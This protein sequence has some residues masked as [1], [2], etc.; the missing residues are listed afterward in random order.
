MKIYTYIHICKTR[1]VFQGN[2]LHMTKSLCL[3]NP[4]IVRWFLLTSEPGP[5]GVPACVSIRVGIRASPLKVKQCALLHWKFWW[6]KVILHGWI[7]LDDITTATTW[8]EIMLKINR[9]GW[10]GMGWDGMGCMDA[11]MLSLSVSYSS[12]FL[13]KLMMSG[14]QSLRSFQ[15]R[16]GHC[17]WRC[18][19]RAKQLWA[20]LEPEC[21][22]QQIKNHIWHMY[23]PSLAQ[24][25]K[26]NNT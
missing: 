24:I 11:C 22:W 4:Q 23:W 12:R 13:L 25:E 2:L 21:E 10:D 17:N 7:D 15:A 18:D 26:Q 9:I 14:E 19:V 1:L 3:I 20:F 8:K 6:N 5:T 16:H